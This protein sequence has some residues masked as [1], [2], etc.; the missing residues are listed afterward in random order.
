[1]ANKVTVVLDS[2]YNLF[3]SNGS[4]I[5]LAG[6]KEVVLSKCNFAESDIIMHLAG[7][8]IE[9]NHAQ[10]LAKDVDT[11]SLEIPHT[12]PW[13]G[14]FFMGN[15]IPDGKKATFDLEFIGI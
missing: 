6:V 3:P 11:I 1:M 12:R 7:V 10:I 2:A 14:V 8:G 5:S 4:P 9:N 15:F 13:K